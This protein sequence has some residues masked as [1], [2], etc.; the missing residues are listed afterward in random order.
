VIIDSLPLKPASVDLLQ[1]KLERLLQT[2]Y[3][4][5]L[6]LPPLHFSCEPSLF[7]PQTQ[8]GMCGI[9]AIADIDAKYRKIKKE[10]KI[11]IDLE[12]LLKKYY[13]ALETERKIAEPNEKKAVHHDRYKRIL[14]AQLEATPSAA[15]K[16]LA[17]FLHYKLWGNHPST[18][19]PGTER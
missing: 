18:L 9:Y 2:N 5:S 8:P 15:L 13:L 12:A 3:E 11:G 1:K 16:P 6:G 17:D 7:K 14:L 10:V 4:K 19:M